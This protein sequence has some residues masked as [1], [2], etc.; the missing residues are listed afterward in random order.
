MTYRMFAAGIIA[1][2]IGSML[3][4][5]E[6]S[7][8]SGG[9][10][11]APAFSARGGVRATVAP[12]IAPR[13]APF[14]RI[15]GGIPAHLRGFGMSHLRDDRRQ[16]FQSGWGY[17]SDAPYG[18]PSEYVGS[19]AEPPYRYPDIGDVPV[20]GRANPRFVYRPDCR[21]DSQKVPSESGGE[22][23]INITRCY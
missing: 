11:A 16:G 4:P 21:T 9:F 18:D 12:S 14:Q 7:A 23:T 19:Y 20:S 17:V 5:I 13:I 8:R 22:R 3:A 1:F 10:I 2:A 15:T 6:T